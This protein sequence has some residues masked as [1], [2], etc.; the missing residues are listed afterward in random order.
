MMDF[1]LAFSRVCQVGWTECHCH[2]LRADYVSAPT[3]MTLER[4]VEKGS[5]AFSTLVFISASR[6][7]QDYRQMKS[8]VESCFSSEFLVVAINSITEIPILVSSH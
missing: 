7:K 1:F 4:C 2:A 3:A 8:E 6:F 5:G